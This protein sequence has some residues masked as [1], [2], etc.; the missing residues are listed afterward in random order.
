LDDA[1]E[2]SSRTQK[3]AVKEQERLAK[4][5]VHCGYHGRRLTRD[6]EPAFEMKGKK[7]R[8]FEKSRQARYLRKQEI[9]KS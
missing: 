1:V 8:S 3:L 9:P 6:Q 4:R 5:A 7:S 2:S